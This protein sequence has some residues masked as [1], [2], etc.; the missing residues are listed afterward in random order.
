MSQPSINQRGS[1]THS[2][3]NALDQYAI[4]D[5]NLSQTNIAFQ[6]IHG[7]GILLSKDQIK[8]AGKQ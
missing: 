4:N 2:P 1:N 8:P 3:M 6:Q 5:Y 7:R